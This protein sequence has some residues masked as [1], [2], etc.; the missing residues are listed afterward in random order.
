VSVGEINNMWARGL[1]ANLRCGCGEDFANCA[2]WSEVIDRAFSDAE[3]RALAESAV[4]FA[5]NASNHSLLRSRLTNSSDT[6]QTR[7]T[8]ALRRLYDS[9]LATSGAGLVVDSSKTP[10]HLAAASRATPTFRLIHLVRDPRGVVYSHR[11]VMKYDPRRDEIAM[12]RDGAAFTT[13]GWAYRNLMLGSLW[14]SG[15]RMIVSYEQ[16]S[17]QPR[18]VIEE[19]LRFAD[20][21]A[22]DLSFIDGSNVVLATEHSVSGNP[23]RFE[24]GSLKIRVD[25]EWRSELSTWTKSWVGATTAPM[26]ISYERRARTDLNHD[27]SV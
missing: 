20:H 27:V 7:Y 3:G 26:R 5:E 18:K 1:K 24:T 21:P 9:V 8:D 2:F 19:I 23:V 17:T 13:A 12:P 11:K 10:W 4:E 15:E 25:D 6:D 22:G 16:F 14:R